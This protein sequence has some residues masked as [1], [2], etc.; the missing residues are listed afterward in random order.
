VSKR[1]RARRPR[2]R[3]RIAH[4]GRTGHRTQS[5]CAGS[6]EG[7]VEARPRPWAIRAF[8]SGHL[9]R[10]NILVESWHCRPPLCRAQMAAPLAALRA[11]LAWG[12]R[13]FTAASFGRTSSRYLGSVSTFSRNS[14]Q[15]SGGSRSRAKS[16]SSRMR[17]AA[18]A[19]SLSLVRRAQS[20][21]VRQR[22]CLRDSR[23]TRAA[24]YTSDVRTAD[25]G[26]S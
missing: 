17:L 21:S 4:G 24:S 9:Q 10:A 7:W 20:A 8:R 19:G 26:R 16:T 6:P 12:W 18:W 11:Y 14:C 22:R 1:P 5:R 25:P 15:A 2:R 3:G 23:N 13:H